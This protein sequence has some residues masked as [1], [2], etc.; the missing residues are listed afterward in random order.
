M[1]LRRIVRLSIP[2]ALALGALA[3]VLLAMESPRI[4]AAPSLPLPQSHHY[5]D[6]SNNPPCNTTLQA[7]IDGSNPA[8]RILITVGTFIT[9]VTLNKAVSLIGAGPSATVLSALP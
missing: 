5:P 1:S 6:P 8:D 3:A 7:C 4:A 2:L 9:S